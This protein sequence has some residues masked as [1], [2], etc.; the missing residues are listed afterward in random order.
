MRA[1][2]VTGAAGAI[3][4]AI[5]RRLLADDLAVVCVDRDEA[6]A[7]VC[8]DLGD[9]AVP[10]VVDLAAPD[11]AERVLASAEEAGEPAVLVNNAGITRDA[12]A[13]KM[14]LEDYALVVRVN[15][16]APLRLAETIG[17]RLAEGG[18]VVNIASRAA[19]GN[20]GQANYVTAKAGLIGATRALAVR[21]APRVRVNVV[22]PGLVDTPM[23]RAMPPAV[24]E[25]LVGRVPA[26]RAG[27][28]DEIAE[29]VAFLASSRASYV[30]GQVVLA[31]GGRSVAG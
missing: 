5:A 24:Y 30:T 21:W 27:H 18:S 11:A 14:S 17:P 3:G 20:F 26:G 6:V 22:A 4:R 28:P 29:V 13:D 2:I 19:L 1:A 7:D 9:L 10:C 23:T 25:K 12:R 31:C 8:H 16:V 15:L